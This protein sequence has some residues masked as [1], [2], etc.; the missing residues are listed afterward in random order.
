MFKRN[1]RHVVCSLAEERN[2]NRAKASRIWGRDEFALRV[3]GEIWNR[4]QCPGEGE[5]R[6]LTGAMLRMNKDPDT[7]L[8]KKWK[9]KTKPKPRA[10]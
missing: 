7:M 3:S 10:S 6:E 2:E 8:D 5:A 4:E 1:R 9:K